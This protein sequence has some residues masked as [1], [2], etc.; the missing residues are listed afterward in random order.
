MSEPARSLPPAPNS[1]S[2]RRYA[3]WAALATL[4]VTAGFTV[5]VATLMIAEWLSPPVDAYSATSRMP[6]LRKQY[7]TYRNPG[8]EKAT[9]VGQEI[10]Q[11][12][13]EL[14]TAFHQRRW[15][16][17]SARW[18][19]AFG[20]LATLLSGHW[21]RSLTGRMTLPSLTPGSVRPDEQ[22]AARRGAVA[23]LASGVMVCALLVAATLVGHVSLVPP[24]VEPIVLR[25]RWP[26]FR[27]PHMNGVVPA[28]TWPDRWSARTGE[29]ILWKCPIEGQGNSSPVVWGDRVFLTTATV[30]E[31]WVHCINAASGRLAWRR[32]V[33]TAANTRIGMANSNTQAL[34]AAKA[35]SNKPRSARPIQANS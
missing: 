31:C 5:V 11:L 34:L 26:A 2:D 27:G 17:D 4:I 13:V 20:A 32:K 30:E 15:L 12:D 7:A 23:A 21:Y 24:E 28:G 1:A 6:A 18:L 35:N 29:N 9:R 25:G 19:L 14:R 10:R 8:S 16:Y 33:S 22:L 3:R